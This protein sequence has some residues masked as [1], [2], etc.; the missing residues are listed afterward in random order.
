MG[1][2]CQERAYAAIGY[3]W[4]VRICGAA[5]PGDLDSGGLSGAK[6]GFGL[7]TIACNLRKP[8]LAWGESPFLCQ[9]SSQKSLWTIF[10]KS[11][12]R[13]FGYAK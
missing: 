1:S 4:T 10:A 8:A 3:E 13:I 9:I 7:K 12:N 11:K 5:S 6:I 2:T